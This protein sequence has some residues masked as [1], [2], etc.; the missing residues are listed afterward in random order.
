VTRRISLA[1]TL[2]NHQ[3]VG[4]FGWVFEEVFANAYEPMVAALERHPAI[5]AGLHYSGPLLEWFEVERPAFLDRLRALVASDQIEILGGGLSEP[6]LAALP[7][8][9]RVGQLVRMADEVERLFGTRP[10]GAWLAE[11]V[12][13]PDVPTAL[14]AAGYRWTILDDSHLRA[15]GVPDEAMWGPYITDDQG[16]PLIVFGTEQGLRYRIPFLEVDAVVEYLREQA[17]EAGERIGTMGDDGEKFGAWPETWEHCWGEHRWVERFFE[18]VEANAEWLT[19]VRPGDWLAA[20]APIG[21]A[22]I[23][24]CSY[25]EMNVWSGGFWRNF[26]VRY[27]EVNDL[28][29]QM[30]RVSAAVDALPAGPVR[31][32]ATDHLYRGQSNDT[33]WHGLF[34]GI[35]IPHMRAA[36][37]GHV[38]AAEDIADRATGRLG[39][40]ERLDLDLDGRDDVRLAGAGQVVTVDLDEGA[41][42]GSWDIRAARH[43]LAAVLRRRPE[44]YHEAVRHEPDPGPEADGRAATIHERVRA[45][46]TGLAAHLVYDGY[47]RRGGLVRILPTDAGPA[48]WRAGGGPDLGDLVDGPYEVTRLEPGR[49]QVRREGTAAG[50]TRLAATKDLRL[51]GGDSDPTLR[52]SVRIEHLAGPLLMARVGVEWPTL[53]LGGGGN[54]AAWWEVGGARTAHDA[55]GEVHGIDRISEGNDWLGLAIETTVA[56]VADAWWAPIETISNSEAGFERVYQGS[57]L[58]LSWQVRLDSDAAWRVTIDHRVSLRRPGHASARDLRVAG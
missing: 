50:G 8:R 25:A 40:T 22:A 31:D 57:A 19:T 48:D 46:E 15:A 49:L 35:Y 12:W 58:L 9:D 3:P 42:I 47:E 2:H 5:R 21:R 39:A 27:R 4:N 55:T 44:A 20:H 33:Y 7:E 51:G 37:L 24:T 52:L 10:A 23:P 29:K 13:E 26:Q 53:L 41:G 36:T 45:K 17:T 28:H 56:P 18:A 1:L 16:H 11:R 14:A 32:E 38:I 6:I 30:L 34:G 54:P 43:P